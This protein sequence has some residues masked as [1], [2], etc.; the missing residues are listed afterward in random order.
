MTPMNA[1][2]SPPRRFEERVAVTMTVGPAGIS[3]MQPTAGTE[4]E[5][6]GSIG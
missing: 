2:T 4:A 3:G 1:T 5:L 6:D